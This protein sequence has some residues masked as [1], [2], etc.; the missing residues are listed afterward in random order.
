M[1][2][3]MISIMAIG[4]M[5][6]AI[7]AGDL[8]TY[9]LVVTTAGNTYGSTNIVVKNSYLEAIYVDAPAAT[10]TGTVEITW[11]PDLATMSAVNLATNIITTDKIFRPRV[12]ATGIDGSDLTS[13]PPVRYLVSGTVTMT[14]TNA[15]ATNLTWQAIIKTSEN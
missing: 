5:A 12:D 1:R 14:V 2:K 9:R 15:S 3:V 13:D 8:A 11:Q 7:Y 4:L 6:C 10:T